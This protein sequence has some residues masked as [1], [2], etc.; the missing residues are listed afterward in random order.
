MELVY[1]TFST[2]KNAILDPNGIDEKEDDSVC[3]QLADV[4]WQLR[5]L[6]SFGHHGDDLHYRV[7]ERGK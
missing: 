1:V 5:S 7:F 4:L 3:C 2:V 6:L